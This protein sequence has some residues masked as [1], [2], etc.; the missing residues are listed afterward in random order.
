MTTNLFLSSLL[1]FAALV[2]FPLYLYA[3]AAGL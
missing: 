3:K 1:I 2:F